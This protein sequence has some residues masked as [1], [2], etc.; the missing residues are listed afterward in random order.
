LSNMEYEKMYR[1][2]DEVESFGAEALIPTS[3]LLALLEHLGST[4]APLVQDQGSPTSRAGGVQGHHR[5]LPQVQSPLQA[6]GASF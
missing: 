5:D 6:Q 2:A 1:D 4:A 3:R